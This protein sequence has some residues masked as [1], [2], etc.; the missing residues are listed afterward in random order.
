MF[1]RMEIE[2][3]RRGVPLPTPEERALLLDY[4]QKHSSNAS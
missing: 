2:M 4:L 3:Q 1:R